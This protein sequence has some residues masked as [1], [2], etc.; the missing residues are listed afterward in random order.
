MH[1]EMNANFHLESPI[2]EN[3]G[4]Q[5]LLRSWLLLGCEFGHCVAHFAVD[6]SELQ[7]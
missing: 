3:Y 6:D 7:L 5:Q 2:W 1:P 4:N